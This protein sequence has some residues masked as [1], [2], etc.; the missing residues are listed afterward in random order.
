MPGGTRHPRVPDTGLRLE[1]VRHAVRPH[2]AVPEAQHSGFGEAVGEVSANVG[3]PV[4]EVDAD[5]VVGAHLRGGEPVVGL[6]QERL[7]AVAVGPATV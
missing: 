5:P 2:L 3:E 4:E 6:R 1:K 7:V